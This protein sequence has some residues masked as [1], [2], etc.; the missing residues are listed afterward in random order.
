MRTGFN[1]LADEVSLE[2]ALGPDVTAIMAL[3]VEDATRSAGRYAEAKGIEEIGE[4]I[5]RRALKYEAMH[6]FESEGLEERYVEAVGDMMRP[7][8]S[9]EEEDDA[10]STTSCTSST[11][12]RDDEDV[13]SKTAV[14]DLDFCAEVDRATCEWDAWN[15]E[16]PI[17]AMI[18]RC[19]V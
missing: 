18:K 4:E 1:T 17:K 19:I 8:S 12:H 6:F 7:D 14:S 2:S 10:A 9:D 16:D 5:M 3:F 15:P 11:E 13:D